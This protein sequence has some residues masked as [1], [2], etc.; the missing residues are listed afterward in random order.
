[1]REAVVIDAVRTPVGRFCGA[2]K[3]VRSD[4]LA[5]LCIS[6]VA[7]RNN[8]DTSKV[9]DVLIGCSNQAG[10]DNRNVGRM[11]LLLAG[12]PVD[13]AGQTIN[14]LCG[15]AECRLGVANFLTPLISLPNSRSSEAVWCIP[16]RVLGA[17]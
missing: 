14:R 15:S 12:F 5:A 2:L 1:M 17:Q 7:K 3:D 13:V 4:D 9:E 16:R 6:E 8:L 11:A 10:D